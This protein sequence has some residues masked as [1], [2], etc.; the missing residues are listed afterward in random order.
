MDEAWLPPGAWAACRDDRPIPDRAEVVLG[1]DGSFSNDSTALVAVE[2]G[3]RPH[4]DVAACWERPPHADEAWRVPI[5][6][7][8]DAIRQACR[9]WQ[10]REIVCDPFRWARSFQVLEDD[11]LPV[12]EF[13]QS[14]ARMVPATQ[15]FYEAVVN[16]TLTHSGDE[17]LARHVGN[18]VLK[19]DSRGQRLAKDTKNSP[20]KIDL[21][22]AAVMAADRAAQRADSGVAGMVAWG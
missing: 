7:V 8:E 11:G 12:V 3:D 19:V 18:C 17:R 5:L 20:R 22:V 2:L 13:P 10:V 15:R 9:R 4:L 21:A 16:K 6:D 14:P 1:F